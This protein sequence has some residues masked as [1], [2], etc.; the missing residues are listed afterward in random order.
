MPEP[1]QIEHGRESKQRV[2]FDEDGILSPC[3]VKF[4]T[5]YFTV[6]ILGCLVF[7]ICGF[8]ALICKG[9]EINGY[10]QNSE[11]SPEWTAS[12]DSFLGIAQCCR[13][14][15]S[16]GCRIDMVL[17]QCS[18]YDNW[19]KAVWGTVIV[20]GSL[21]MII[22]I[23]PNCLLRCGYKKSEYGLIRHVD[24]TILSAV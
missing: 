22:S 20:T 13:L 21:S 2:Q 9:W 16:S 10:C 15:N 19:V 8:G 6:G 12:P 17:K 1:R 5:L 23:I 11:F 24:T 14:T 7:M 18:V 3:R 4:F